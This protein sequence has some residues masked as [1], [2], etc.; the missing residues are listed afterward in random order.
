MVAET[1]AHFTTHPA[2][3]SSDGAELGMPAETMTHLEPLE[4]HAQGHH[5]QHH[6]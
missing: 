1:T 4:G 2:A 5:H 3:I 6:T